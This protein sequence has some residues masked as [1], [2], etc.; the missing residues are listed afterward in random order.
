MNS[1][2][3]LFKL[4]DFIDWLK[5]QPVDRKFSYTHGHS[6][7]RGILCPI[8]SYLKDNNIPFQYVS[9]RYI[10]TTYRREI[11][12]VFTMISDKIVTF[13]SPQL[14]LK[15]MAKQLKRKL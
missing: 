7:Q 11:Q 10:M 13:S 1:K 4:N 5:V 15:A 9:P 3:Y 2:K 12:Q 8:A 6:L 14:L